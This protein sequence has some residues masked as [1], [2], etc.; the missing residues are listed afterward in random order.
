MEKPKKIEVAIRDT[1]LRL[2]DA[3]RKN[4]MLLV[5]IATLRK[6]LDTLEGIKDNKNFE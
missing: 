6:Q 2:E 4:Q 5:E 3:E 1:K